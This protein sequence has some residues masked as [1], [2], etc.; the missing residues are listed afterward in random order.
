M[1]ALQAISRRM[2]AGLVALLM[3]G[4]ALAEQASQ[5]YSVYVSGI[6]AGSITLATDVTSTK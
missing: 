1:Q 6:K 2:T 5:S 4:P 3:V